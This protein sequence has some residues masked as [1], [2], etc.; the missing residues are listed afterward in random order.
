MAR[1]RR[2]I[3]AALVLPALLWFFWFENSV[4][5]S[6]TYEAELSSLPEA[7]DGF[8]LALVTDTQGKLFGR[9]NGRLFDA[10]AAA[11]PDAIAVCGDMI[12]DAADVAACASLL[13]RLTAVAPVYYVTGNH[14]WAS[15]AARTLMAALEQA[16]AA[17]LGNDYRVLRRG[18]EKIIIAGV[19]DPNGP[20]DMER[21]E[22]LI[23]RIRDAE[24]NAP[25]VLLAHRND[26][27]S[28]WAALGVDLVL[29]GHGHGGVV[30]LPAVGGLL[31]ADRS[32]FPKYSAGLYR[33][34]AAQM[35]VS[36]GLGP[37]GG[38][39]RLF[40]RPDVPV[41]VLRAGKA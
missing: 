41:V 5:V 13:G 34:G 35:V 31:G 36:R 11:E 23:A 4:I 17:V 22:Q 27:L 9:D 7:F 39:P 25:I 18:G 1:L 14:E 21:P 3:A 38:L 33:Q 24:G 37:A 12:E 32:L 15:G 20:Y 26:G 2:R 40:N 30:R 10:V 28:A 19:H 6:E 8:R 29:C 16:G